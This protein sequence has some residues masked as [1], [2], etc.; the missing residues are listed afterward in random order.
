MFIIHKM[1]NCMAK[2]DVTVFE[3]EDGSDKWTVHPYVK[4]MKM[5]FFVNALDY[6]EEFDLAYGCLSDDT[7][8][9]KTV[10]GKALLE[11]EYMTKLNWP[12]RFLW[13]RV[14]GKE[15]QDLE[16]MVPYAWTDSKIR[17]EGNI[18]IVTPFLPTLHP[19][20]HI[21]SINGEKLL[22]NKYMQIGCNNAER[23]I[24]QFKRQAYILRNT[25]NERKA[26]YVADTITIWGHI[27]NIVKDSEN[28]IHLMCRSYDDPPNYAYLTHHF[29]QD[30]STR[31]V[32]PKKKLPPQ[33]RMPRDIL[34]EYYL[35]YHV[36]EK[37]ALMRPPTARCRAPVNVSEVYS[38]DSD[39]GYDEAQLDDRNF[40]C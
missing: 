14:N 13:R 18:H 40:I 35:K 1:P 8:F 37:G 28:A 15:I 26:T 7:I 24:G 11:G 16:P 5:P 29:V 20:T 25:K 36:D 32:D 6:I 2:F 30:V 31:L 21:E 22:T 33:K 3:L 9:R 34:R 23:F 17:E 19:N 10:I 27:W 4:G 12:E 38:D 39:D